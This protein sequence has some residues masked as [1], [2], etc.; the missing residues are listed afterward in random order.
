MV[1][2]CTLEIATER[3]SEEAVA[4]LSRFFEEE[5]FPTPP[6]RIDLNLRAMLADAA[7]WCALARCEGEAVG[8]VTVST[9]RYVEQGLLGEVGDLYVL[10]GHRGRGAARLLLAEA[11]AWCRGRGCSAVC[12][13]ITPEGEARHRLSSFYA[14]LGFQATGRTIWST[15][16]APNLR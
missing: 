11:M 14:R 9:M 15:R 2:A 10:P 8:V 6:A 13:T 12:V 16:L 5:D 4:L 3:S 1:A 7:C